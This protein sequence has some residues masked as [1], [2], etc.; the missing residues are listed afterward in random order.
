VTG[1][2][3]LVVFG[4]FCVLAAFGSSTTIGPAFSRGR[5]HQPVTRGQRV[6]LVVFGSLLVIYGVMGWTG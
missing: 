6:V 4:A 5:G 3:V 2:L 1:R